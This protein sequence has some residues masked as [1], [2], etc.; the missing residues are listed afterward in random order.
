MEPTIEHPDE[1]LDEARALAEKAEQGDLLAFINTMDDLATT[2]EDGDADVEGLADETLPFYE[3]DRALA[4]LIGFTTGA[5]IERKYS[6]H[7]LDAAEP[8]EQ[9]DDAG[10][11]E[12]TV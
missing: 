10:D 3:D 4:A 6:D 8:A 9:D 5:A 7:R 11:I 12:D 2:D 1:A